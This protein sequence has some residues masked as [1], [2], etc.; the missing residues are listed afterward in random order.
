RAQLLQGANEE[1]VASLRRSAELSRSNTFQAYLAYGLAATG[2]EEESREALKR[3]AHADGGDYVRSECLAAV[4]GALGE[5]DHA[6]RHLDRAYAERSAGL[7]YLH[8]DPMYDSLR[9][10]PRF[11]A[12]VERIGLK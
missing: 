5:P 10:D 9:E 4:Y 8:L 7:I 12:M 1:A 2:H 11:Q 6:F 3:I